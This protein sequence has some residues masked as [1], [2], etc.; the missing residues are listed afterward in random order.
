MKRSHVTW[1]L[2][3]FVCALTLFAPACS[4]MG[5][6]GESASEHAA[7]DEGDEKKDEAQDKAD[8]LAKKRFEL[9]CSRLELEIKKLDAA[10]STRS[11]QHEVEEAERELRDARE[12]LETFQTF[13]RAQKLDDSQLDLDQ[14][15][16]QRTQQQQELDELLAMYKQE[17]LAS[18]TKE[19]VVSRER[20]QLEFAKRRFD[21]QAKASQHLQGTEIPREEREL[22]EGVQKAERKLAEAREKVEKQKL[23]TK[24]EMLKAEHEISDAEK[25]IAK[26]EKKLKVTA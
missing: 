22:T 2:P 7:K 25:E 20:K 6:N 8:E 3:A 14:A 11:S 26:L 12:K 17:E 24:L 23:E 4:S 21:M 19:L 9:E 5:S 15:T 13:E 1:S 10:N 16:Q 18:L